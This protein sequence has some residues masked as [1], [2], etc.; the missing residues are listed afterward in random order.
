MT[1]NIEFLIQKEL[2]YPLFINNLNNFNILKKYLIIL[3]VLYRFDSPDNT[4]KENAT[5][6]RKTKPIP[7]KF[8]FCRYRESLPLKR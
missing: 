3:L 8:W 4:P 7:S 6:T 5:T 2:T 1:P